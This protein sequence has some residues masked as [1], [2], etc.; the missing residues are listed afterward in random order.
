MGPVALLLAIIL[1]SGSAFAAPVWCENTP[2][3]DTE[4][5]HYVGRAAG[6]DLSEAFR[7][8]VVQARKEAVE[9]NFGFQF[10][11]ETA[12]SRKSDSKSESESLLTQDFE[13]RSK[14]VRLEG[15]ERV[16]T[17]STEDSSH[18]GVSVCVW[19]RYPVRAV[20]KELKRLSEMKNQGMPQRSE[21]VIQGSEED[22]KRGVAKINSVPPGAHV[23]IDGRV[24]GET[25]LEVRGKLKEGPHHLILDHPDYERVSKDFETYEGSITRV[26]EILKRGLAHIQIAT[27]PS[28]AMVFVQGRYVG[29]SPVGSI[30]VHAGEVVTVAIEHPEAKRYERRIQLERNEVWDQTIQ[31]DLKKAHLSFMTDPKDA[32]IQVDQ[33]AVDTSGKGYDLELSAGGHSIRIERSGFEALDR[34]V[35]LRGGQVSDLGLIKMKKA[36]PVQI[37]I[38]TPSPHLE[39]ESYRVPASSQ[40]ESL[41]PPKWIFSLTPVD[42]TSSPVKSP[43]LPVYRLGVGVE[44]YPEWLIGFRVSDFVGA[45]S[46]KFNNGEIDYSANTIEVGLPI[47]FLWFHLFGNDSLF[48]EP[49][50]S[51]TTFQYKIT[52]PNST[53]N[54]SVPS[55]TIRSTGGD[56]GYRVLSVPKGDGHSVWGATI[57]FGMDLDQHVTGGYS[58]Q[59]VKKLGIELNFGL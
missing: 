56:V 31:L 12:G 53:Q 33:H 36:I 27:E 24:W 48:I 44:F 25:P 20:E 19:F 51:T 35:D 47:H 58:A 4:Y 57:R 38:A 17:Y 41:S 8:A 5:K 37:P 7:I 2:K 10:H 9:E 21:L 13:E 40:E 52:N 54:T 46:Q 18:G 43:N 22:A 49:E 34:S 50:A 59:P 16:D 28:G 30:D 1:S 32:D 55:A 3:H 15:F 29:A 11:V 14:L 6:P 26:E 23:T 45:G 42:V 39:S